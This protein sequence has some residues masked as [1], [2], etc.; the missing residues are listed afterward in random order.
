[1]DGCLRTIPLL[2]YGRMVVIHWEAA[3]TRN[4]LVHCFVRLIISFAIIENGLVC[5]FVSFFRFL[6]SNRILP[7][8]LPS[9]AIVKGRVLPAG[10]ILLCID[11]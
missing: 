4:H 2:F 10:G 7:I 3:L 9:A 5:G 8:L 11:Y 6:K 1:M